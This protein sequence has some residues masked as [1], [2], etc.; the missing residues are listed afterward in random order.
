MRLLA[1]TKQ[2]PFQEL[3]NTATGERKQVNRE[4]RT[5]TIE[6]KTDDHHSARVHLGVKTTFK[7]RQKYYLI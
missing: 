3:I 6:I 1:I 5:E 2:L 7:T 4:L